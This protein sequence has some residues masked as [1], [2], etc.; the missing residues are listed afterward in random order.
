MTE[1]LHVTFLTRYNF[2]VLQFI[3]VI[4]IRNVA[5]F[6]D[7]SE[8]LGCC[9]VHILNVIQ[10]IKAKSRYVYTV[11]VPRGVLRKN[12][13]GVCGSNYRSDTLGEGTFGRKHTFG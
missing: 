1:L 11:Q 7:L 5:V 6:N 10:L 13:A 4:Q 9:V 3:S 8:Y 2:N 12:L